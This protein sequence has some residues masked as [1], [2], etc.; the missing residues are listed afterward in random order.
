M[1]ISFFRPWGDVEWVMKRLDP[2]TWDLFGCLSFEDRST[3]AVKKLVELNLL[4]S[5]QFVKITDPESEFSEIINS[6]ISEIETEYETL[7]GTE[8]SQVFEADLLCTNNVIVELIESFLAKCGDN[9]IIDVTC[10]PKRFFFPLIK[11]CIRNTNVKNL[12][13]TYGKPLEYT[14]KELS[15]DPE[16]WDHIPLFGP[17]DF[18][19][20]TPKHAMVGV[21]FIPFGLSNLLKEKYS[22]TPVTFFFPF[23]PGSPFYQR[24]WE[25]LRIIESNYKFKTD[26]RILRINSSD[27]SDVFNYIKSITDG[28]KEPAIFAPYGP[29]PMSIAMAI[30]S[31]LTNSPVYYTQPKKYSPDYSKGKGKVFCYLV[32]Q[33]GNM[34]YQL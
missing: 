9:L 22:S 15:E 7:V 12:L 5:N 3:S 10:L 30:Y 23:P 24:S 26:D 31:T 20:P 11:L 32:K 17:I 8:N 16:P 25:F 13:I 28:G 18:P 27:V 21:G 6:K 19:E 34:L 2:I 1:D 4:R 29:K 14:D 33:D